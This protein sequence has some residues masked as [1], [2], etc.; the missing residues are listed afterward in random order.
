MFRPTL[1]AM[2]VILTFAQE[3]MADSPRTIVVM[4]GSGSMWGQIDG[5]AKLEIARD[6]VAE[7]LGTIPADQELGLM[8]YGHRRKGD[9]SD[10]ELVVPPAKGTA[11]AILGSVNS[12]KFLGKTPLSQAVKQA[13]QALRYSED[14][15]TVVLVTDGLETCN[16][17]PCAVAREL[18][19]SGLNFT[20]HVIGFGLTQKEGAQV[21]CLATETGGRY[22][23]AS[24]A[25][26]L[27]AAL[28]ETIAAVAPEP[29]PEPKPKPAA[30]PKATLDA[31][32]Q[33][34]KG[35]EIQ[36][37][38][39]GPDDALDT[40]EIA[41]PG[42]GAGR[43]FVYVQSGNPVTLRV[44]AESG[45]YELRYKL[46]DKTTLASR[47]IEIVEAL[48][49]LDAP[50]VVAAGADVSITW[51]GPDGPQDNIQIAKAGTDSYE[52]YGYVSGTN[53][54]VL[55]AP[56]EPGDYEILYK[57]GDAEIIGRRALKIVPAGEA[58]Q[59]QGDIP[60]DPSVV[61]VTFDVPPGLEGVPLDWSA[62]PVE[63][64]G[65]AVEAMAM[66]EARA[67]GW[68]GTLEPG[69]WDVTATGPGV[70]LG[71]RVQVEPDQANRF[72]IGSVSE[73]GVP[74]V[75]PEFVPEAEA[76]GE[77]APAGAVG[78]PVAIA[79]RGVFGFA[80][81]WRA[82][83]LSGQ[84]SE[85]LADTSPQ[86]GAWNTR[87]DPGI[88]RIIGQGEGA[89]GFVYAGDIEVSRAMDP[90]LVMPHFMAYPKFT[91]NNGYPCKGKPL[92]SVGDKASGL[93][94]LLQDG[95]RTDQPLFLETAAG[96]RSAT[97]TFSLFAKAGGAEQMIAILN[98][99]Q[100]LGSNG[101]CVDTVAGPYCTFAGLD[102]HEEKA[103]RVVGA[104]IYL[105]AARAT[106]A[107]L[108]ADGIPVTNPAADL[109]DQ[110]APN[111]NRN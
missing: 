59:D 76:M 53:P 41:T 104:S 67:G 25:G 70:E 20:A 51:Q 106:P 1:A 63:G 108:Q 15:A 107:T 79:I 90:T 12:M 10:I 68:Q 11:A 17:D 16:A 3:G 73:S 32:D 26:S 93:S 4:D 50:D 9:C 71:A 29:A 66:P 103:A 37:G 91:N 72:V 83:P 46:N 65:L 75:A 45:T 44:P 40:I 94:L 5:R 69:D 88:W 23:Q 89:T 60:A 77:D 52:T 48:V 111:W 36:V 49:T 95:Y 78:D 62:V 18:E 98:P 42:Q 38:W 47:R 87:L 109:F 105:G 57:F 8:A 6:T 21:A 100:W 43:F 58:P 39:T 19:A 64:S 27:S 81:N 102:A 61:P 85:T 7:V 14:A 34:A 28:R 97:P 13:A 2:A 33:A 110:L 30:L 54:L 56:E 22:I 84:D 99:S 24:D 55:I 82:I 92:C 74:E 86:E 80:V 35:S 101:T 31:P 96:V